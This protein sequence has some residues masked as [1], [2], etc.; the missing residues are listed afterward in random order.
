MQ[1]YQLSM[2]HSIQ[3]KT[4]FQGEAMKKMEEWKNE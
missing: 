1:N 4:I 3:T 2:D